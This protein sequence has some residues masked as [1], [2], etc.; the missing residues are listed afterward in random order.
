MSKF[1][2]KR[3]LYT[4]PTLFMVA[5]IVFSIM[6]LTP[7]DPGRLVLGP[8]A[9][10][11]V[12]DQFN[13]EVGATGPFFVRFFRYI[14]GIVTEFDFGVSYR[15][16]G[17]VQEEIIAR[18]PTT[19]TLA[20]L[21]VVVQSVIG[22][23]LGILSAVKQYSFADI[24]T[25]VFAMFMASVPVFW[26]GLMLIYV[27]AVK[28]GVLP[29]NGIGTW[30][31]YILPLLAISI[32]GASTIIK[33]T[34]TSM[35]ETIRQDYVRTARAKG[36]TEKIVIWKH[37]FQNALMPIITSLAMSFSLLLGGAMVTEQVFAIPG[38]GTAMITAIRMKDT[39]QVMAITLFLAALFC[40]IMLV[41]DI[42]Y[43]LVD[44]RIKAKYIGK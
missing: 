25:T 7:G 23:A 22:V 4:I 24:S 6:S 40:L 37:A 17:P 5:F 28:M 16:K 31:H 35:L 38:L 13:K 36:A 33:M 30:K 29:P 3:I 9:K 8:Q 21:G 34:R 18:F 43:A 12:V 11:E 10:Q 26:F 20:L 27:F 41:V 42:A 14:K 19:L 39:P 32:P 15:T 44:P 2:L 1:I